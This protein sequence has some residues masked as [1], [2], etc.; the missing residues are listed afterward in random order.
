MAVKN[1]KDI[2][3]KMAYPLGSIYITT[4]NLTVENMDAL[5]PSDDLTWEIIPGRMLRQ[6]TSTAT[7]LGATGGYFNTQL[8]THTHSINT[9][10]SSHTHSVRAVADKASTKGN[11]RNYCW[12]GTRSGS[13][14][15]ISGG[16]HTHTIGSAGSAPSAGSNLPVYVVVKMFR[17]IKKT[18]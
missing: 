2:I 15:V 9:T 13:G 7:T 8:I 14:W 3:I 5:F 1:L 11:G 17:R 10:N 12:P 16:A 4:K 18:T 6:A